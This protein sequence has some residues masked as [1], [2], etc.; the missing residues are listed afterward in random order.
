VLDSYSPERSGVGD[1][2]LKEADRLTVVGTL[3]N[4]ALQSIRNFAAHL[5]FRFAASAARVR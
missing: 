1:Q 2:V 5:A 4:P 3:R